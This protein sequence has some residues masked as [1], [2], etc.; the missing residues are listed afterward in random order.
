MVGAVFDTNIL[1]DFL[2]GADEAARELALYADRAISIVA[3]M[4]VM[5]GT[6]P[7]LEEET[8]AFLAG[9]EI[10]ELG[11]AVARDAV[12]LRRERRIRLPDAVIWASARTS[13]RL[14][15]TR[16]AK[17]FP[18]DDP[19]VRHPYAVAGVGEEEV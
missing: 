10:V 13:G 9:F 1:V 5:V 11:P 15:I 19:G 16:D 4:E 18:A 7:A 17:A 12:I 14:L 6:A 3:W 8:R 2:N